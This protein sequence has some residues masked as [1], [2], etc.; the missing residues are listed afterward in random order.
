MTKLAEHL[1]EHKEEY[2]PWLVNNE[3]GRI[4]IKILPYLKDI[5]SGIF[6]EAGALDGLFMSNTKILE[7]LG[8]TGVLIEPSKSAGQKCAQNRKAPIIW[9]ALVSSN[10]KNKSVYGTFLYDGQDGLGARSSMVVNPHVKQELV[11]VPANTMNEVLRGCGIKK[12]HFASIDVEGFELNVFKG[13][14][15]KEFD[16]DYVLTEVNFNM[17]DLEDMEEMMDKQGYK[18]L[19]CISNFTKENSPGWDEAHQDYLFTKN[20]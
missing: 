7:D 19:G 15:L 10:Y 3:Q 12:V 20:D 5:E 2:K 18:N 13:F 4:D 11:N 8:W 16:V 14:N 9:T 6:V 1:E 17:Y